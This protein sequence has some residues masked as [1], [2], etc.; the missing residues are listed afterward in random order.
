KNEKNVKKEPPDKLFSLR[1]KYSNQ[2]LIDQVFEALRSTRKTGKISDSVLIAE[3]EKWD[4]HPV[5]QVERGLKTYLDKDYAGDGKNEAYLLGIIRNSK[6]E[7][8]AKGVKQNGLSSQEYT[9]TDMSTIDW[10]NGD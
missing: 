7:T 4:R 9:G 3:L 6:K 2:S 5:W 8:K 1:Q 10:A